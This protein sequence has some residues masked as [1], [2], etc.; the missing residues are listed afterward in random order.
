M[1]RH[2]A[3]KLSLG[4]RGSL[5]CDNGKASGSNYSGMIPDFPESALR[6]VRRSISTPGSCSFRN[7]RS[8][9]S[10]VP[11]GAACLARSKR[12]EELMALGSGGILRIAPPWKIVC[13]RAICAGLFLP[14]IG[15]PYERFLKHAEQSG[16]SY[17]AT[18]ASFFGA[19]LMAG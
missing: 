2:L 8:G 14:C 12:R 18:P 11:G 4:L 3:M 17:P 10:H 7:A 5:W 1:A 15:M 16:L 6:Q 9:F 19:V 13:R